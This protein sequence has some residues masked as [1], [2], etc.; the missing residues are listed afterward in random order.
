MAT[1]PTTQPNKIEPPEGWKLHS[2][3]GFMRCEAGPA[4]RLVRIADIVLWLM[5]T[6]ELPCDRAVDAV[7]TALLGSDG[8]GAQLFI[9]NESGNAELVTPLTSFFYIP[10]V[11]FWD[12]QP[13]GGS[14]DLGL[15]GAVK[16]MRTMWGGQAGPGKSNFLGVHVIDPLA[17]RFELASALWGWGNST[18]VVQL[19]TVQADDAKAS[20]PIAAQS[21]KVPQ[22]ELAP[23]WD[24][25][26]LR[27]RHKE[28]KDGRNKAPTVTL[29]KESGLPRREITRRMEY[30]NGSIG[31]MAGQLKSKS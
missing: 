8:R 11:S 12:T 18:Q 1:K 24:G 17:V 31:A 7:C 13:S 20:Q 27:K 14:D 21:K 5:E 28:L 29:S 4:D 6:K 15:P 30:P 25:A 16:A 23:E 10:I 19:K 26:R 3:H 22:R 2:E 9:V